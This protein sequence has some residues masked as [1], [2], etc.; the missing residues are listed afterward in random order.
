ME[1]NNL[2]LVCITGITT[3]VGCQICLAFLQ[4]GGFKV[5]GTMNDI[6]NRKMLKQL[7]KAYGSLY[8]NLEI[9]QA[10]IYME[11]TLH[12]AFKGCQYVIHTETPFV[13]DVRNAERDL[14]EPSVNGITYVMR[15]AAANKVK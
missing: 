13:E 3:F 1:T 10:N 7:N 4:N 15:A 5:R 11:S 9:V 12:Q 6:K 2:P 8:E 14:I